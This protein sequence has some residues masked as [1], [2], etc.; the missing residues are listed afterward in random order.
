V[1]VKWR[2]LRNKERHVFG[3]FSLL[4][5]RKVGKTARSVVENDSVSTLR[6]AV[7]SLQLVSVRGT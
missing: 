6:Q 5:L 7:S 1:T 4:W 3:K 2:K